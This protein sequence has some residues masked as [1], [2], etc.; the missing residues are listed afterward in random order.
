M[1][2]FLARVGQVNL[3]IIM[4]IVRCRN[5][6]LEVV[7]RVMMVYLLIMFLVRPLLFGI[8]LSRLTSLSTTNLPKLRVPLGLIVAAAVAE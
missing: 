2:K 8:M 5:L 1:R 4:F 3:Q 7:R 6:L